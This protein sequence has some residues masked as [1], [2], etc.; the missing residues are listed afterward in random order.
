ML[1]TAASEWRQTTKAQ[2]AAVAE[3]VLK[4]F[5]KDR[6]SSAGGWIGEEMK[7]V[8]L[9]PTADDVGRSFASSSRFAF[10]SPGGASRL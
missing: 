4:C 6:W 9:D 7:L 5:Q 10:C 1:V 3:E 2:R 8:K